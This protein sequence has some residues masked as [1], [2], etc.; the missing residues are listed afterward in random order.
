MS[1]LRRWEPFRGLARMQRDLDR[2]FEDFFGRPLIESEAE[3]VRAPSVDVCETEDEVIVSAEMP[4]IDKKD[5][6]VEVL[7]ESVSVRAEMSQESE[8]K[9]TTY[10][11]KERTWRRYERTIPLPAEVVSDQAKAKLKD[12]VLEI[13]LPKSE[14]AKAARPK[15]VQIE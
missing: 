1:S 5:L 3:G 12:G 15:K 10:H 8:Q 2:A 4:G 14:R 9:E 6:E 7:P 11:R 13:W